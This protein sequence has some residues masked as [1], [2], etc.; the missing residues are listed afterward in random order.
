LKDLFLKEP[1]GW[2]RDIFSKNIQ[3]DDFFMDVINGNFDNSL[4]YGALHSIENKEKIIE[5]AHDFT[6]PELSK[7]A[8]DLIKDESA[9]RSICERTPTSQSDGEVIEHARKHVYELFFK[10][11]AQLYM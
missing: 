6:N 4:K 5:V 1:S 11:E 7:R 3:D 8:I 10:S 2:V 9:L